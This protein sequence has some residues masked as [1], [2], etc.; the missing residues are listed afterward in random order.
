MQSIRDGTKTRLLVIYSK[1][2]IYQPFL[3]PFQ[4]KLLKK[5][6]LHFSKTVYYVALDTLYHK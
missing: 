6:G 2:Q 5:Y 1:S 3:A 4:L